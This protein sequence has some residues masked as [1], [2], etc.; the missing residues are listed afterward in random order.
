[1]TLIIYDSAIVKHSP[2]TTV[3]NMENSTD[4]DTNQRNWHFPV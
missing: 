3:S 2:R 1:M 4:A